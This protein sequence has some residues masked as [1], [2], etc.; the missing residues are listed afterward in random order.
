MGVVL[1]ASIS[2]TQW[3]RSRRQLYFLIALLALLFVALCLAAMAAYVAVHSNKA[4]VDLE[5][6]RMKVDFFQAQLQEKVQQGIELQQRVQKGQELIIKVADAGGR[7]DTIAHF[8]PEI[9]DI[10]DVAEKLKNAIEE[11]RAAEGTASWTEADEFRL[12]LAKAAI[13]NAQHSYEE[14]LKLLSPETVRA[15]AL[16]AKD[17]VDAAVRASKAVATAYYGLGERK[18][19]LG[20]YRLVLDM[21]PNDLIATLGAAT[22]QLYLEQSNDALKLCDRVVDAYT[23]LAGFDRRDSLEF[24]MNR[25]SRGV[26]QDQLGVREDAKDTIQAGLQIQGF[27]LDALGMSPESRQEFARMHNRVGL[28]LQQLDN[29]PE[30]ETGTRNGMAMQESLIA[31]EPKTPDTHSKK[32]SGIKGRRRSGMDVPAGAIVNLKDTANTEKLLNSGCDIILGTTVAWHNRDAKGVIDIRTGP[33]GQPIFGEGGVVMLIVDYDRTDEEKS[34]FIVESRWGP[35]YGHKGYLY[36]TYDY[37]RTY[38]RY[39]YVTT[40]VRKLDIFRS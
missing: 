27:L 31:R 29:Q 21:Y 39:G 10:S 23:E 40:K 4:E 7:A 5:K 14:T 9:T 19:A 37:I 12:R 1:P 30:R 11:Y 36:M 15:K 32:G 24:A 3:I 18:K 25:N 8:H 33:S 22:C 35:D 28:L 17:Q 13:A 38:A 20:Y 2:A 26:V 34:Y 6:L 16:L